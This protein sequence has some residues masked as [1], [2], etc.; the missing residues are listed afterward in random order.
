VGLCIG[1][2]PF[3]LSFW[4]VAWPERDHRATKMRTIIDEK[5][6]LEIPI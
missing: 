3:A 2:L 4:V 6:K 1:G 5:Q